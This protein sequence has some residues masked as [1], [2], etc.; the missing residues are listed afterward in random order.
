MDK[1][2]VA[3]VTNVAIQIALADLWASWGIT[4]DAV[5]GHS[6][7][8]IAAAH[9]A[10]ALTLE[11]TMLLAYHRS[12]LQA[13]TAGQGKM[14]AAGITRGGSGTLLGDLDGAVS[15]AAVNAPS[16]VTLSG[17]PDALEQLRASL[18]AEGRFARLL[19]V[20]V[21]YHSPKMDPLEEELLTCLEPMRP[22]DADVPYV[23][24]VTG[25]WH[26]GTD[27][28]AAYWW[29]NVRRPVRF[30]AAI[31][32]LADDGIS[33]FLEV[34]PHPVLSISVKE[35][36]RE[37]ESAGTVLPSLRRGEDERGSCFDP[38]AR[39]TP[40]AASPAGRACIREPSLMSRSRPIPGSG[41]VT[42]SSRRTG[43]AL[44]T[45]DPDEHPLLG[46]RLRTPDA[47][48]EVSLGDHR[49][50]YLREHIIQGTSLL[51]AAAYVEMGLAVSR[52]VLGHAAPAVQNVEFKRALFLGSEPAVVQI[53]ADEDSRRFDIQSA[54][55]DPDS[56]WTLHGAGS[57]AGGVAREESVDLPTWR[58]VAR[59]QSSEP[60]CTSSWPSAATTT[61]LRSRRSSGRARVPARPWRRLA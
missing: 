19:P 42:G 38:W 48:W 50:G 13:Q 17:D 32:C 33:T 54:P 26:A 45:A 56:P 18:E 10:G 61:G 20:D 39:S 59:V 24:I 55:P 35:C 28:G 41:S 11:D 16:S 3:Q 14:L 6:V 21:P 49:L 22:R 44:P 23:S 40:R 58:R 51:P 8:E 9:V 53:A 7:G 2:D 43:G 25:T 60:I 31:D 47:R 57:L 1:A 12:R 30:G 36:L 37:K 27:L 5:V 52:R 29:Q 34:G 4:P 15:L 46:R